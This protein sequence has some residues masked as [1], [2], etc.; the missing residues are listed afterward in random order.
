MSKLF[1]IGNSFSGCRV[2]RRCGKGAYGVVYLAADAAK[3]EIESTIAEKVAELNAAVKAHRNT[4]IPAMC[5]GLLLDIKQRNELCKVYK[6][7]N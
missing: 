5:Q 1:D 7:H 2:L 3:E 4:E 6:N